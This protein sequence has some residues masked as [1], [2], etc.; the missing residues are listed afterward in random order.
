[1]LVTYDYWDFLSATDSI[2][3]LQNYLLNVA[4]AVSLRKQADSPSFQWGVMLYFNQHVVFVFVCSRRLP[5]HGTHMPKHVEVWYSP[6]T[7]LSAFVGWYIQ[8][9]IYSC[10]CDLQQ[11]PLRAII[12]RTIQVYMYIII[13]NI[14]SSHIQLK[15]KKWIHWVC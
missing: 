5:E 3:C 1:M 2:L 8:I 6:W 11:A 12:Y 13:K 4:E 15:I 9:Q 10:S 7:V 14:R